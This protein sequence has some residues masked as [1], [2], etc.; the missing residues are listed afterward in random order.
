[1]ILMKNMKH[2]LKQDIENGERQQKKRFSL[3]MSERENV[4]ERERERDFKLFLSEKMKRGKMR[5]RVSVSE[6]CC[7]MST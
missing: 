2:M 5:S 6:K 1:M 4:R 3:T 7:H